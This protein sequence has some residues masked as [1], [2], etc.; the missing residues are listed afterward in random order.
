MH[1]SG[2]TA[3]SLSNFHFRGKAETIDSSGLVPGIAGSAGVLAGLL[4]QYRK[5]STKSA[6]CAAEDG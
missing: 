1:A 5:F 6:L 2:V 4:P 3:Y